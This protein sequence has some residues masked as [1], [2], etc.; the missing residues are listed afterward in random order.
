MKHP[1]AI[2]AHDEQVAERWKILKSGKITSA[3]APLTWKLYKEGKLVDDYF[4]GNS[5]LPTAP[6]P[7]KVVHVQ[8][9]KEIGEFSAIVQA[10][11]NYRNQK[12]LPDNKEIT[13]E[14]QLSL[15]DNSKKESK[16]KSKAV[17]KFKY[18]DEELDDKSSSVK[19][20]SKIQVVKE[21]IP[22]SQF[23]EIL[24]EEYQSKSHSYP[25]ISK[26]EDYEHLLKENAKNESVL[27]KQKSSAT[28]DCFVNISKYDKTE[29]VNA[30]YESR[31]KEK[32]VYMYDENVGYQHIYRK[33]TKHL[34]PK[35]LE[36]GKLHKVGQCV[37]DD[38]GEFLYKIMS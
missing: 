21:D 25:D 15:R 18:A 35:K 30:M 27:H 22:L 5:N 37:Y 26:Y 11:V 14:N 9:K 32:I 13:S 31:K 23:K 7:E 38:N 8:K 12:C 36:K 17:R 6:P 19:P 3:I 33:Q 34:S 10:Y 4:S 16:N 20:T 24:K 28:Q 2:K 1:E 29:K